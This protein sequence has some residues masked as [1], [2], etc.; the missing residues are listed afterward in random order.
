MLGLREEGASLGTLAGSPRFHHVTFWVQTRAC[1]VLLS[2][3]DS[4]ISEAHAT[5]IH[6]SPYCRRLHQCI[7]C[8]SSTGRPSLP[9]ARP[10]SDVRSSHLRERFDFT[11]R[12]HPCDGVVSASRACRSAD[13]VQRLETLNPKP[14]T[15]R[16]KPVACSQARLCLCLFG[17]CC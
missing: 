17:H 16:P 9:C 6:V 1:P 3:M 12:H 13:H 15:K 8:S 2:N 5:S 7:L 10:M 11:T 14:K 4:R